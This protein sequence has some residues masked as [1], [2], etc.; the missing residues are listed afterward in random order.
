MILPVN[1]QYRIKSDSKQW[2]I[3]TPVKISSRYPDGWK[4]T[5][6]Y[7]SLPHLVNSLCDR[8]LRESEVA[9]VSEALEENKRIL[10]T[11][12]HAL[13]PHYEVTKREDAA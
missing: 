4:S 3:Q 1:D 13:A 7:I 2:V 12:T 10:R 5:S 9:G 6:F 11:L 8:M